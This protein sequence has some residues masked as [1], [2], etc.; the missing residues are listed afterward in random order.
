MTVTLFEAVRPPVV[1]VLCGEEKGHAASLAVFTKLDKR[2]AAVSRN[3]AE[4]GI[5][6]LG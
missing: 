2:H 3:G 4:D 1:A 6:R 5:P